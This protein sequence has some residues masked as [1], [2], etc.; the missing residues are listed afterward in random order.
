MRQPLPRRWWR[1]GR[2]PP[3]ARR[4]PRRSVATRWP[5][6]PYASA[7][8]RPPAAS[9]AAPAATACW[10]P[11]RQRWRP[12]APSVPVPLPPPTC[13]WPH[14]CGGWR[15]GQV[16]VGGTLPGWSLPS[17]A[18]YHW[19]PIP[20]VPR[21]RWRASTPASLPRL[22]VVRRCRCSCRPVAERFLFL[23][24]ARGALRR[25]RRRSCRRGGTAG[26][27]RGGSA[28]AGGRDMVGRGR[29]EVMPCQRAAGVASG[30]QVRG[31]GE[32]ASIR[33]RLLRPGGG[34]GKG[35][36]PP[37]DG[38]PSVTP[39]PWTVV[40]DGAPWGRRRRLLAPAHPTRGVA[41][42]LPGFWIW[43]VL[44]GVRVCAWAV[45]AWCSPRGRRRPPPP[46]LGRQ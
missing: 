11:R 3:L 7:P 13:G 21:R 8:P 18:P 24:L 15:G 19:R 4:W 44:C 39:C 22:L 25:H 41:T 34:G 6:R 17:P 28:V 16:L 36:A 46:Q 31:R 30:R 45:R 2:G 32:A 26:A 42:P 10:R 33:R 35:F 27:G 40:D 29:R 5:P 20:K 14:L 1:A 23:L 43:Y 12:L 37:G 9:A 38:R